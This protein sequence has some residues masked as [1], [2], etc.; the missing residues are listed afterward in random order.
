MIYAIIALLHAALAVAYLSLA[1]VP[2]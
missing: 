2:H 1:F